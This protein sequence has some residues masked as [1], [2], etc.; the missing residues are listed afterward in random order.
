MATE[1][2][3]NT[4]TKPGECLVFTPA[5]FRVLLWPFHTSL[6]ASG[7]WPGPLLQRRVYNDNLNRAGSG[8]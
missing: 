8:Q 4:Q 2:H 1:A 3:G 5:L 6:R 7:S